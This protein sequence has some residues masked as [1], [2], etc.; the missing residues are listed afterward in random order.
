M[1]LSVCLNISEYTYLHN[2]FM[3]VCILLL[4]KLKVFNESFQYSWRKLMF[5]III[6]RNRHGQLSGVVFHT[7]FLNSSEDLVF[8]ISVVKSAHILDLRRI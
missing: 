8:L 7:L 5:W 6:L 1:Y 2:L 4:R 3:Y